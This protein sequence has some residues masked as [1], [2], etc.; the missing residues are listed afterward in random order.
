MSKLEKPKTPYQRLDELSYLNKFSNKVYS[1]ELNDYLL[2]KYS[3]KNH[4]IDTIKK[5]LDCSKETSTEEYKNKCLKTD[6]INYDRMD[7]IFALLEKGVVQNFDE[8]Y[9]VLKLADKTLGYREDN[10]F[11]V[12]SLLASEYPLDEVVSAISEKYKKVNYIYVDAD[13]KDDIVAELLT[14]LRG[15][16]DE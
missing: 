16:I 13:D 7:G 2:D 14:Q 4:S 3:N 1:F 10:F 11:E 15:N 9:P 5:V 8:I 6:E 12:V